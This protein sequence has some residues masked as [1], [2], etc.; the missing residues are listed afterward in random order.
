LR[1]LG[2]PCDPG[3]PGTAQASAQALLPT[4]TFSNMV[5]RPKANHPWIIENLIRESSC[6]DQTKKSAKVALGN[7]SGCLSLLCELVR[8][9]VAE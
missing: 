9:Q 4:S 6:A 1:S 8:R 3:N 7:F 5:G 2:A